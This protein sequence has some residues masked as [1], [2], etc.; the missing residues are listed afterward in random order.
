MP[1]TGGCLYQLTNLFL[2]SEIKLVGFVE[3]VYHVPPW[4]LI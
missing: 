2:A 4:M 3:L 1:S